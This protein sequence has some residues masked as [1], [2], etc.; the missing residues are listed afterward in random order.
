LDLNA[1]TGS[2]DYDLSERDAYIKALTE[3]AAL[4]RADEKSDVLTLTKNGSRWEIQL[5]CHSGAG[6]WR[7]QQE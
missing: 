3:A 4:S 5:P 7:V 2:F 6:E 1:G